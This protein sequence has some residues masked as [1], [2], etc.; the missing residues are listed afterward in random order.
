LDDHTHALDL[1][2]LASK[3]QALEAWCT[4]RARWENLSGARIKVFR[5]DNGGEFINDAF[6]A[7]LE[8]AGIMRQ[9]SAPYAHQQNGKAERV[10]RTI[11]GRMYAMLDYAHL[12]PS[13]WGEAALTACY[14]FNRTESR[15]LPP[16][17]T[18]YE[19]LHG[20]QPN[21]AHLRVFGARCFARI[22]TELQQKLGPRSRK[23]IFM[24]YPPGV[25]AWRCQDSVTGTFFNSRDV[26][27]D[28]GLS[29][30]P[31]SDSDD[32]DN[33]SPPS[34]TPPPSAPVPPAVPAEPPHVPIIRHSGRIPIPS[35][36]GQVFK[37]NIARLARQ[38]EIRTACI[39][40]VPPP[41]TDTDI[42]DAPIVDVPMPM[43][44]PL[45]PAP[46]D[47]DA[48]V[49]DDKEIGFP[50]VIA[51]LIIVEVAALSIRSD[52]RHNPLASGYDLGI[53]PATYDE[54]I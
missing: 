48:I 31:F 2:L 53:P 25:K 7:N 5:S 54:A 8:E 46:V 19:M 23:A 36:K 9:R 16:G 47:P 21:L 14:L 20:V 50:Q 43:P 4:L 38:R 24:G 1:Q 42:A 35:A 22:P 11:E 33:N 18:P 27:F 32:D 28:E 3:D 49:P 39:N 26:I 37:G 10:M 34:V 41:A 52:T 15:A 12:S 29:T 13:L 30:Q 51:N 44:L 6:T 17:K 45:P 40:R